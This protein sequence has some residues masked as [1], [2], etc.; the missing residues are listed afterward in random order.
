M[1]E[2]STMDSAHCRRGD[3]IGGSYVID[4][5]IGV[6]GM[7][8]V[9]RAEQRSTGR[10][11]VVKLPRPDL[12]LVPI[13][14]DRF[15]IEAFAGARITHPNVVRVLDYGEEQARPFI[16][17][18]EVEG[19]R[20]RLLAHGKP[21]VEVALDVFRQ[22]LEGV[23][24]LH[25]AG[26]IH[27]DLKCDNVLV[28]TSRGR[29]IPRLIDFGLARLL[30]EPSMCDPSTVAG[31]PEYLAPELVF[32]GLPTV[33]SDLY[34]AGILLYELLTGTT[35]FR[36]PTIPETM[37][38]HQAERM[39]PIATLRPELPSQ[40]DDIVAQ[41]VAKV[42][43]RRFGDAREFLAA[44]QKLPAE[45]SQ[46][47][48]TSGTTMP[49][50]EAVDSTEPAIAPAVL[51][52]R[53]TV[54]A[55]GNRDVAGFVVAHLELA[56]TLIGAHDLT[57]AIRELEGALSLAPALGPAARDA[58]LWRLQL[59]LAGL[60]DC[61]GDRTRARQVAAAARMQALRVGSSVGCARADVLIKRLG[62]G[63]P[64]DRSSW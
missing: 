12:V 52:R 17:M 29:M 22:L 32:G 38:R 16:V 35:P 33:A 47:V 14:R 36:G 46:T 25:A 18:D 7:G 63:R 27:G 43:S 39:M 20:L 64:A 50:Q 4:E 11:V 60:Y 13:V 3:V 48:L 26:V 23:A 15:R 41:A 62:G 42:P 40:L 51:A 34:A 58:P 28:E 6:G 1:L 2:A 8:V 31:T 30:G 10:A 54:L 21:P 45:I 9:Y 5:V 57:T 56:E 49:M 59:M 55:V 53:A 24:E 44:C 19:A 37:R 61:R